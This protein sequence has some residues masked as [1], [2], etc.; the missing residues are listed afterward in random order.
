M[1]FARSAIL[2]SRPSRML[3][4]AQYCTFKYFRLAAQLK[5]CSK[6]YTG[7]IPQT[8][9]I[10]PLG[11]GLSALARRIPRR[12]FSPPLPRDSPS[13]SSGWA[14]GRHQAHALGNCWAK[15]LSSPWIGSAHFDSHLSPE[16][17]LSSRLTHQTRWSRSQVLTLACL[18]LKPRFTLFS[19]QEATLRLQ[20]RD[21]RSS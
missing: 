15:V 19:G 12:Y 5:R 7:P 16:F 17:I 10:H 14:L 18:F 8:G 1:D 11:K 2:Y 20:T 21:M 4:H 6:L 13:E 3:T 9:A